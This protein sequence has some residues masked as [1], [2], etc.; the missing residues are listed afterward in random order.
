MATTYLWDLCSDSPNKN[1]VEEILEKSVHRV[2]KKRIQHMTNWIN[3][4]DSKMALEFLE[5]NIDSPNFH[6]FVDPWEND[7][8]TIKTLFKN[9][10]GNKIVRLSTR[11]SGYLTI[12]H[13]GGINK[14]KRIKLTNKGLE[15]GNYKFKTIVD[16]IAHL[17]EQDC[18]IC[19]ENIVKDTSVVLK[20]G[21]IYH[22]DCIDKSKYFINNYT[23]DKCPMCKT[24]LVKDVIFDQGSACMYA[25]TFLS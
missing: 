18:C 19:L 24:I 22:I 23:S 10:K 1:K 15:M 25:Q 5:N 12:S 11:A 3:C 17:D 4:T 13:T 9:I 20:C 6:P 8:E 2:D 7:G 21:H 16:L 14:S